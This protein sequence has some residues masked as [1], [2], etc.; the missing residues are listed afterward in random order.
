MEGKGGGG[1]EAATQKQSEGK[2]WS[3][4]VTMSTR[5]EEV[6]GQHTTRLTHHMGMGVPFRPE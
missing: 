5:F 6:V 4:A 1:E 2:E 3:S